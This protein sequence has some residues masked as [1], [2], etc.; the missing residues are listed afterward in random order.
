MSYTS[1]RIYTLSALMVAMLWTGCAADIRPDTLR[2]VTKPSAADEAKGRALLA[3]AAQVQGAQAWEQVK[4][5]TLVMRDQW[6]GVMPKLL[7]PWPQSDVKLKMSFRADSFDARA[8]FLSG[9]EQGTIWGLQSWKTYEI[10]RGGAAEFKDNEDAA[11]IMPAL[12]YLFEFTFREH[13]SQVV[14]Y[15]GSEVVRGVRYERVFLTWEGLNPSDE[16]DQ[17]MVY[18]DEKSGRVE[19]IFYTVRDIMDSATGTIHFDDWR[20]VEG[21]SVPFRQR[22]TFDVHDD[23]SDYAHMVT[24]TSATWNSPP[25]ETF[26]V[27]DKL[28]RIGDEKPNN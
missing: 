20:N 21:I 27:D 8:E 13:D 6:Q 23:P 7:N 10:K 25:V 12:Q 1:T 3:R 16:V 26:F 15:A 22:V 17:Y 4:T 18:V 14:T 11:F 24:L 28:P 9:D 19:K 5:Y 2:E